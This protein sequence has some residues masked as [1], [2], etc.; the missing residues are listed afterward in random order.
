VSGTDWGPGD[1]GGGPPGASPEGAAAIDGQRER[2][3]GP[4]D[5]HPPPRPGCLRTLLAIALVL[6]VLGGLWY[7]FVL[8]VELLG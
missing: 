3:D 5:E 1:V 4:R 6:V 7:A 8:A 2:H